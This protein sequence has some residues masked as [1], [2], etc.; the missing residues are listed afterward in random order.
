MLTAIHD[1]YSPTRSM[2]PMVVSIYWSA[3]QA[4]DIA[5]VR[6]AFDRHVKNPDGGQFMPKPADLIRVIAGSDQEAA[7][8][9]WAKV[10]RAARS[11][12]DED[13]V[14]D[15]PLIHRVIYDMGGWTVFGRTNER[16]WPF[17]R[18]DFQN[19]YC[20]YR[21][22]GEVPQYPAVLAGRYGGQS[23]TPRLIG[24]PDIASAV[25]LGGTDRPIIAITAPN[26]SVSSGVPLL[27]RAHAAA[28]NAPKT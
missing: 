27:S 12:G 15:D 7:L 21:R 18:K 14:F 10:G 8:V 2:D 11:V 4:Y 24:D 16:D 6:K 17:V 13:V 5:V 28:D 26:Y 20:G 9:A 23:Q 1:V 19:L 22:V 25:M 3:L